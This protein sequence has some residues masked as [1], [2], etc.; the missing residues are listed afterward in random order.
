VLHTV[1]ATSNLL[2]NSPTS[3]PNSQLTH[4]GEDSDWFGSGHH[5][6]HLTLPRHRRVTATCQIT[7]AGSR[8]VGEQSIPLMARMVVTAI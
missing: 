5:R 3:D 4:G 8:A 2:G 7:G 6:I 1:G